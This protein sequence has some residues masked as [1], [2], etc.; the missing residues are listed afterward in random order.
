MACGA[1]QPAEGDWVL[2]LHGLGRTSR[3]MK[4]LAEKLTEAGYRVV[5]V[6][7]PSTEEPFDE[8][9]DGL[10]REIERCCLSDRRPVH[11]VTHS[12]GG[13]VVR[14]YLADRRLET[15]GRVVML[16]PPNSGSVLADYLRR[17]P[18][19]R[20]GGPA[21]DDLGTDPESLPNRLGGVDYPVGVITGDR[22]FNPL[23]SWLIPGKDDGKVS[24]E[25]A[26]VE[27]MVDFLVV[28][29]THTF[30]MRSPEVIEQVLH[31]LEKSRFRRK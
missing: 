13:I 6:D 8:L 5:L 27:G 7:Y 19:G 2:L 29:E 4:P 18:L 25:T 3:S 21:L 24:V 15:L 9:V 16:S 23:F 22:S 14:A 31:F 26:K 1:P 28:P 20:A 12:M 17:T 30:I 10:A 11:F